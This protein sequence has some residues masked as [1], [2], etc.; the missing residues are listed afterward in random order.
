MD[1]EHRVEKFAA[2]TSSISRICSN[3]LSLIISSYLTGSES[4]REKRRL[5]LSYRTI[6][7]GLNLSRE[8][9]REER[10]RKFHDGLVNML[11]PKAPPASQQEDENSHVKKLLE[12]SDMLRSPDPDDH[13]E[14]KTSCSSG[15][16]S[17]W[18]PQKLTR[19]QRKRLRKKK[20]KDAAS[21]RRKIIGPLMP[22]PETSIDSSAGGN[23]LEKE[24]S[25]VRCNAAAEKLDNETEKPGEHS[26]STSRNKL[27]HRRVA[28][29]LAR[30]KVKSNV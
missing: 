17:E 27:K 14:E 1:D 4:I 30:G 19:A 8:M 29:R 5:C 26:A 21:R 3:G 13:S 9:R 7:I 18:G 23:T 25:P 6:D 11:Y 15:H 22:Q 24:P 10:R 16:E 20:L 28:K 2:V 12:G